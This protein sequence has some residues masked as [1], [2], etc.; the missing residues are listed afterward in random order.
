LDSIQKQLGRRI[1]L[2]RQA[3]NMKQFE[4][5]KRLDKTVPTISKYENGELSV[6]VETLFQMGEILGVSPAHF[7][8]F[9]KEGGAS[10]YRA[11]KGQSYVRHMYTSGNEKRTIRALIEHYATDDPQ[12]FDVNIFYDIPSFDEPGKC[13]IMYQGVM[14][15]SGFV[16]SYQV[17]NL[18]ND[19]EHVLICCFKSFSNREFDIGLLSGISSKALYPEA[20]KVL[21]SDGPLSE[22]DRLQKLLEIDSDDVKQ[23]IRKYNALIITK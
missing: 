22:D 14:E 7:I 16:Y 9:P 18:N 15:I 6:T 1:R 21:L 4:F 11:V 2:F 19:A 23:M 12:R 8:S 3:K 17:K 13:H 5:A 10:G 20:I